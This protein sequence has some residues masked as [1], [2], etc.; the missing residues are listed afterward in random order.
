MTYY[1]GFALSSAAVVSTLTGLFFIVATI[2][3]MLIFGETIQLTDIIRF[4][5]AVVFIAI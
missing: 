4:G 2:V 3:G 5:F 1:R